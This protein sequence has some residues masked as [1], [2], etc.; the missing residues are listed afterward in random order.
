MTNDQSSLDP[1]KKLPAALLPGVLLDTV[2]AAYER[3][4]GKEI[5]SGKFFSPKSSSALVANC[6]G[7]FCDRPS[8][9]PPLQ[10]VLIES[11]RKLAEIKSMLN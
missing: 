9:M 7:W 6:L 11:E 10:A 8:D 4:L 3:S 1:V 2:D 5:S